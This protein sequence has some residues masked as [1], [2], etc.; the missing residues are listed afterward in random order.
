MLIPYD[1]F[2]Q[3]ETILQITLGI[4]I[5]LFLAAVQYFWM[6]FSR[7]KR[8]QFSDYEERTVRDTGREQIKQLLAHHIFPPIV[9]YK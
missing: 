3:T 6:R 4:A 8:K 9:R 7:P 2:M 5:I 1:S